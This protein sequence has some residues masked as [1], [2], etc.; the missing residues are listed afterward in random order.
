MKEL[1]T[2]FQN[3]LFDLPQLKYMLNSFSIAS[4]RKKKTLRNEREC[5]RQQERKYKTKV[6]EDFV[7]RITGRGIRYDL[8]RLRRTR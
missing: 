2:K 5:H 3:P 1:P 6:R 4:K 7:R 8:N